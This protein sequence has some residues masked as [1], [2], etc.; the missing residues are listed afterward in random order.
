MHRGQL[1][2]NE[3]VFSCHLNFPQLTSCHG[4]YGGLFRTGRLSAMKILSS[5]VLC[6]RGM[7]R[8]VGC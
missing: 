6:V 8:P 5:K 2:S 3:N 7:T 4:L 1:V